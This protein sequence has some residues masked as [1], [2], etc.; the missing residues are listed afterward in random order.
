MGM[1]GFYFV[2]ERLEGGVFFD[3][4]ED[5]IFFWVRGWGKYGGYFCVSFYS[6][7]FWE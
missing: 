2:F 1:D 7:V 6:L 5:I 3:V 4:V